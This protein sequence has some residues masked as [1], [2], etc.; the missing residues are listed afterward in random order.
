M[1]Y[2]KTF[3]TTRKTYRR[4]RRKGRRSFY[5]RAGRKGPS[6][7]IVRRPTG[8][9]DRIF[10]KLRYSEAVTSTF[11]G[12]GAPAV[13]QWRTNSVQDPNY[14]GVGHQP[15]LH[16]QFYL[17]YN[18]YRVAGMKY[19]ITFVNKS[20]TEPQQYIVHLRPNTVLS[21]DWDVLC[22]SPYSRYGMLSVEGASGIKYVYG[23]VNNP[24]LLGVSKEQHRTDDRFQ[25]LMGVNPASVPLL[26]CGHQSA[27][28]T[29]G[30][31][32]IIKVDL[33]YYVEFFDRKI[34]TKS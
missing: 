8:L 29:Q 5:G 26:T 4:P 2:G 27:D 22:E 10:T 31:D 18:R 21:T 1:P 12:F 34:L 19:K 32:V 25:A 20:A 9:P 6:K 17:L 28:S 15:A 24:T 13:Y 7:L 23:Y 33:V 16:D 11:T 14:T 3:K 30:A